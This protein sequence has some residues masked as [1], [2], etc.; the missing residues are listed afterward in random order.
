MSYFFIWLPAIIATIVYI[1]LCIT[2]IMYIR[3]VT[4]VEDS[5]EEVGSEI[6]DLLYFPE[7]KVVLLHLKDDRTVGGK[8]EFICG[9]F[10]CIIGEDGSIYLDKDIPAKLYELMVQAQK[11]RILGSET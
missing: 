7:T 3:S 11:K 1:L 5:N 2:V 4:E 9:K 6:Q 10:V 8:A